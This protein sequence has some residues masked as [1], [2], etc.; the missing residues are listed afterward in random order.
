MTDTATDT[1]PALDDGTLTHWP[2][3][4]H[5]VRKEDLPAKEGTIALCGERLMG[6]DLPGDVLRA[7]CEKCVEI[8]RRELDL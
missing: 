3:K 8:A 2:P 7:S 1:K 5:I 6:I 4:A